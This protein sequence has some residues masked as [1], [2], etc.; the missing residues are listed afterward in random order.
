MT[1]KEFAKI[2][3]QSKIAGNNKKKIIYKLLQALGAKDAVSDASMAGEWKES[4]QSPSDSTIQKWLDN[5]CA[6][7]TKSYF[8][9]LKVENEENAYDFSE[10]HQI[11]TNGK[12]CRGCLKN[13]MKKIKMT[14]GFSA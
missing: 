12:N 9:N 8:P 5:R 13:G 7:S 14:K 4:N 6:P 10:I 11:K 2:I 1:M 3:Q